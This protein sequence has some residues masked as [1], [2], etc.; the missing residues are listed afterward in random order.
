MNK[1]EMQRYFEIEHK[2]RN[3]SNVVAYIETLDK[4]IEQSNKCKPQEEYYSSSNKYKYYI[5][6]PYE[7]I[8]YDCKKGYYF[9]ECGYSYIGKGINENKGFE[10]SGCISNCKYGKE[11]V[12]EIIENNIERDNRE[13]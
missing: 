13:E 10:L 5:K 12:I 8:D 1:E 4:I 6:L 3:N 11:K 2:L 9:R 7:K